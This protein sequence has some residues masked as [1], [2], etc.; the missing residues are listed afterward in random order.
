[1]IVDI[2]RLNSR[3][4]LSSCPFIQRAAGTLH[5]S[6]STSLPLSCLKLCPLPAS[7]SSILFSIFIG[8]HIICICSYYVL[9]EKSPSPLSAS[10][11]NMSH[12]CGIPPS[13]AHLLPLPAPSLSDLLSAWYLVVHSWQKRPP[14]SS[15][16]QYFKQTSELWPVKLQNPFWNSCEAKRLFFRLVWRFH[17]K[18]VYE[19]RRMEHQLHLCYFIDC[20]TEG[21]DL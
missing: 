1:M 2:I 12:T 19:W 4:S 15:F 6:S 18:F 8:P 10:G 5:S 9:L 11:S 16:H 13:V 21:L 14:H 20:I 17:L 7:H 3:Q